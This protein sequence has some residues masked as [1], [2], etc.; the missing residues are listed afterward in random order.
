M[1]I[2]LR[3]NIVR[4]GIVGDVVDVTSGYARNYLFPQGLAIEPTESNIRT[5]AGARKIAERELS[6]RRALLKRLA[7]RIEGAEVTIEALANEEGH[8]YGSV[9]VRE[10]LAALAEQGYELEPESIVLPQPI[11]QLDSRTVEVHLDDD[12]R[13]SI[14]VWVVRPRGTESAAEGG[15]ESER[16]QLADTE[17]ADHGAGDDD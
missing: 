14:K 8:L 10:V 7:E 16:E 13:A 3:K 6:E 17:A 2:L 12:A 4:L 9:G 15:Q 1:K 5:L 11:R